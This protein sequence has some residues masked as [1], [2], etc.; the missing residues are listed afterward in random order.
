MD[1]T[2]KKNLIA[3]AIQLGFTISGQDKLT[4]TSEQLCQFAGLIAA[5]TV[6][7]LEAVANET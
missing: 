4:C 6:E 2:D 7:Q 5:S 3:A 1:E